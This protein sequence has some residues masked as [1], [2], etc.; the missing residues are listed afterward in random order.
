[1]KRIA[2]FGAHGAAKTS[3][4]YKL[5]AYFKMQDK[6]VTVIHETARQS[7]FP[8]NKD[9]MY[10]TTLHVVS[11]QLKKELEAEAEG[12]EISISD[13]T[14]SDAF[15]YINLLGRGNEYTEA[16]DAFCLQWIKQY[17]VLIYLEPSEDFAPTDDGIRAM[18][19]D[20]Q[21]LVRDK[22]RVLVQEIEDR[23]GED[24]SII[25]ASSNHIF[26]EKACTIL[27]KQINEELY[28]PIKQIHLA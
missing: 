3:L 19:R 12:F 9:A 8:I 27:M 4:V 25:K 18:D 11:S 24:V 17:D 15:I 2:T 5:A 10:Q 16:L 21:L 28:E 14:L 6:N 13:R 22:F 26:D 20:Y 23:Y 7:P 1:M